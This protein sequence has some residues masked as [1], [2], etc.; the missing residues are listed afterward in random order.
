MR[1]R[2]L[3]LVALSLS[4]GWLPMQSFA[5]EGDTPVQEED[6]SPQDRRGI[7]ALRAATA[8][9]HYFDAATQ[10]G[11]WEVPV[12]TPPAEPLECLHDDT[13][14]MGYHFVRPAYF[15]APD[16]LDPTKPQALI[17]APEKNGSLRL[18]AVEFLVG[19]VDTDP[20]P[21][22]LGQTFVYNYRF[23]VWTL[24]VWAWR[25]NPLGLF[26]GMN[27]KVSCEYGYL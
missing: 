10:A 22:L 1:I 26:N 19:G 11:L 3:A 9:Y 5:H 7:A 15:G 12:P 6:L 24:H 16:Q 17:Y 23:H 14:G 25:E 18:V 8:I 20:A 13:G 27:P 2:S 4:L 21:K